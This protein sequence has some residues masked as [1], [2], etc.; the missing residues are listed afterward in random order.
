M[1]IWQDRNVNILWFSDSAMGNFK[2]GPVQRVKKIQ[3]QVH[4]N[5]IHLYYHKKRV[6]INILIYITFQFWD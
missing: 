3:N 1:K 6:L 5:I 4:P 2:V